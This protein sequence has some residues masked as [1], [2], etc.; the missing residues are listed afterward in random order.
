MTTPIETRAEIV[1]D[2]WMNYRGD[3]EF[4]DFVSYNDLGLPLAYAV[5][6]NIIKN[7][8]TVSNM[9]SE[10]FDLLLAALD[11]PEDEGYDTLDDLLGMS[12]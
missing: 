12:I 3:D 1:A 11:I 7:N 9:I 5:S 4:E 10:T 8:E 6:V 2:L